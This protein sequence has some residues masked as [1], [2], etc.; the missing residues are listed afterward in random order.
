MPNAVGK[1]S[2]EIRSVPVVSPNIDLPQRSDPVPVH[3]VPVPIF[4]TDEGNIIGSNIANNMMD[5]DAA[6]KNKGKAVMRI[7]FA[8]RRQDFERFQMVDSEYVGNSGEFVCSPV[9][10]KTIAVVAVPPLTAAVITAIAFRMIGNPGSRTKPTIPIQFCR[11]GFFRI[12]G[13]IWCRTDLKK[14]FLYFANGSALNDR[15]H[16]TVVFHHSL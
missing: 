9:G 8:L 13:I 10:K 12:V 15:C 7:L 2:I 6:R 16:V 4:R 11:N 1:I 14:R 5:S 3:I